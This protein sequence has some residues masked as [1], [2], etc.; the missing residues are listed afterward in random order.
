MYFEQTLQFHFSTNEMFKLICKKY[1]LNMGCT[2]PQKS[3]KGRSKSNSIWNVPIGLA[4]MLQFISGKQNICSSVSFYMQLYSITQNYVPQ[5]NAF[6]FYAEPPP[7]WGSKYTWT[8]RLSIMITLI[9]LGIREPSY[10][11]IASR[12]TSTF[13]FLD[14]N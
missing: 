6:M 11:N 4:G 10:D 12:F 2:Y 13:V 14:N 3:K 8:T 7:N 5:R 1:G 9:P